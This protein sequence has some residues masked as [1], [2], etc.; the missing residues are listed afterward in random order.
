MRN[1]LKKLHQLD[2]RLCA[3]LP[4]LVALLVV[5]L[6]RIPTFFE[7]Y[8]YGDEAIYLTIG[9]ALRQGARLYAEIID[10][11]TPLI[12]YLAMVPNQLWFRMLTTTWMLVTTAAF[13]Y[14]AQQLLKKTTPTL[15]ATLLF[16]L[17][18]SLPWFEGNI[19]NGELFVMG[20]ILV[21]S[22]FFLR[23][24]IADG[25]LNQTF[26]KSVTITSLPKAIKWYLASGIF[27]G[28]AILTKVPALFDAAAFLAMAWFGF[29]A[30]ILTALKQAKNWSTPLW[31]T[32]LSRAN[33]HL[34][35]VIG[36]IAATIV[37]SIVY[38]VARGSGQAY[39]DYGLLYNFRYVQSW[40]LPFSNPIVQ[41]L[42][43]LPGKA[44]LAGLVL[45][46]LTALAK[47]ISPAVQFAAGWFV[48]ALFASLL[49]NRPYP[50]YFLQLA[51]AF[52][53]LIGACCLTLADIWKDITNRSHQTNQFIDSLPL[54]ITVGLISL[55]GWILI[56]LKVG[57]Y[58]TA[59]YYATSWKLITGQISQEAYQQSFNHLMRDN[60][61]AAAI[62]NQSD[63]PHL[64]IWGT[65]PMLYALSQKSPTG[66]FTVS[67][68]I[69]D[70]KAYDETITSVIEKQPPFIVVMDNETESLPGL[71]AYLEEN[72]IMNANFEHFDLWKRL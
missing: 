53:L 39:L 47:K 59:S 71:T 8:W 22:L 13:Y 7:P 34:A 24:P 1:A 31:L 12:Y 26:T 5:I 64:F 11:K 32:S 60:Y 33:A 72:Y 42:F 6:L 61:Q 56:S 29:T 49:S 28:L 17:V 14:L 4:L 25:F 19:P 57:L 67:F 69:H 46:L 68:H 48:L 63:N 23:T 58:P 50:H 70:F 44:L 9:V 3:I 65:N 20:F 10:H 66:R 30:A 27:F 40:S 54:L 37:S 2:D 51:P 43:T 38:F 62:I 16:V 52:S 15:I 41:F 55:T 45:L 18:T 35:V 36:G 21:G